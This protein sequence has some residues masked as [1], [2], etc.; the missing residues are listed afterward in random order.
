MK[1]K[2]SSFCP[3]V[4]RPRLVSLW[5]LQKLRADY[6]PD[7][8]RDPY[9]A[10]WLRFLTKM[11]KQAGTRYGRYRFKRESGAPDPD[12]CAITLT[13]KHIPETLRRAVDWSRQRHILTEGGAAVRGLTP[14]TQ[15][16]TNPECESARPHPSIVSRVIST[17]KSST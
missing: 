11:Q 12:A 4:T 3:F 1:F 2:T 7:G 9:A 13:G 15:Q 16:E 14:E 5:D 8:K 6:G 17:A 10:F